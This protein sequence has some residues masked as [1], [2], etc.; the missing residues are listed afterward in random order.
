MRDEKVF[1]VEMRHCV[2]QILGNWMICGIQKN[3]ICRQ[4]LSISTFPDNCYVKVSWLQACNVALCEGK[5][6]QFYICL[7]P[8]L[9]TLRKRYWSVVW[10]PQWKSNHCSSCK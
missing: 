4:F 5:T 1:F 7:L 10:D 8:T 9:N 2:I 3:F 6:F